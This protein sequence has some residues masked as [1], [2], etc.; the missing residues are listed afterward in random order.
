MM[1]NILLAASVL[2]FVTAI[3]AE[4]PPSPAPDWQA[5]RAELEQRFKSDQDTREKAHKMMEEARAKG[6]E[7][8]KEVMSKLQ[9]EMN[10]LDAINQSRITEL[11]DKHGWIGKSKVGSLAASAV[12]LIVQHAPL[13]TQ[14]KYLPI[15][16]AAAEAGELPKSS[17]ALTEDRVRVRQKQPQLYGSQVKPGP[18]VDLFLVADPENLDERRKAMGLGPVCKYLENFVKALGAITYPPC[19]K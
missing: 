5:L 1:R 3:A 14:L 10:R 13:E 2:F 19:V 4:E 18:G 16:R 6:V 15:M 11:L 17:L 12:Y 9:E 7:V 8:D